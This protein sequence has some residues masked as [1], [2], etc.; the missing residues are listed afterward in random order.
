MGMTDDFEVAVEEGSTL[1]R[2]G[3]AIF[4]ARDGLTGEQREAGTHRLRIHGR[5][6]SSAPPSRAASRRR[7][8]SAVAEINDERRV[9]D[10]RER[11]ACAHHGDAVG[12]PSRAPTSSLFAVKPQEFASHR[13]GQLKRRLHAGPDHRLDHGRRADRED[14]ARA[15]PLRRSCA[16]MPNTPATIGEGSA[17]GRR[18]PMSTRRRADAGCSAPERAGPGDLAS[19]TRSTSTWRRRCRAAGPDSSSC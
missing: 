10:R 15:R 7:P 9:R 12:M 5:G 4:G 14:P 3:R 6:R 1:V 13:A 2:V 16:S 18:R 8:T 17:S 11:T 19:T